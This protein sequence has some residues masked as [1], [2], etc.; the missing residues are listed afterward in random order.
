MK[1]RAAAGAKMMGDVV[2]FPATHAARQ[3]TLPCDAKADLPR[4][5]AAEVRAGVSWLASPLFD[6]LFGAEDEQ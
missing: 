2:P 6:D 4:C 3:S 1:R 5:A